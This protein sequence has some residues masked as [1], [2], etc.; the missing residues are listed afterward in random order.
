[1]ETLETLFQSFETG[2]RSSKA[3][4]P[5]DYL[6]SI[7]L[8]YTEMRIGFNS[9]QFHHRESQ[10]VKD[11]YEALGVIKKSLT[12]VANKEDLTAY[13]VFG[14]Y[15]VIFPLMNK[16][17]E[18]VN[19][20]AVRFEKADKQEAYLNKNGLFP[21]YPHQKTKRLFITPTLMD[22]AS[23]I[24]SKALDQREAVMALHNGKF[25]PQH[26]EA[27]ESLTELEEIIIIKR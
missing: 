17:N 14:R 1:M 25:L 12:A 5:K 20:F 11:Q 15:G 23:F 7:G 2:I 4:K 3:T 8:D 18:I 10:E 13:T 19:F 6:K 22:C 24:Q 21:K 27:I 26:R 9:G 16:E